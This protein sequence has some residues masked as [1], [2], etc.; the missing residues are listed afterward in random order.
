MKI[1]YEYEVVAKDG[2]EWYSNS[3]EDTK[4]VKLFPNKFDSR[5]KARKWKQSYKEIPSKIIQFKYVFS[6]QKEVH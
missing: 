6:E 3:D 1:K 4:P 2:L 5:E